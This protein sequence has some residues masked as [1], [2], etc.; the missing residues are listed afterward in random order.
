LYCVRCGSQ[1]QEGQQF[2]PAC[3]TPVRGATP[4]MPVGS[5]LAGHIRLLGIFWV[6]VSAFRLIPGLF[7]IAIFRPGMEFLP[8]EM[9]GFVVSIIH[10]VGLLLV[11]GAVVGLAAGMGLLQRSPWARMLAIVLGFINLVD[12]PIGTALGIYTLWVLLPA[13]SEQEYEQMA[14]AA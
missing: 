8:P 7:L 12:M 10:G 13:Q 11:V 1:A 9:P 2:C 3:G 5:R 6:A 4:L 14:R